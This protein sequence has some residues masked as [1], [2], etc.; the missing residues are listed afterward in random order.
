[1]SKKPPRI[2]EVNIDA[3]TYGGDPAP[4]PGDNDIGVVLGRLEDEN[5]ELR[6]ENQTLRKELTAVQAKLE[7][8][9]GWAGTSRQDY[10]RVLVIGAPVGVRSRSLPK[11]AEWIEGQWT[12]PGQKCP[13][14]STLIRW[15]SEL[16]DEDLIASKQR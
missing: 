15:L 2:R 12:L 3:G 13:V 10:V 7:N 8:P 4:P 16:R 5:D 6:A 1:M 11:I 9:E 14:R